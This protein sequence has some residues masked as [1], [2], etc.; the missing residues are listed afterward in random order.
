MITLL[1][2]LLAIAGGVW[3][4]L[5]QPSFGRLPQ[6]ERL[7]RI[8]KS[9]HYKDGEFK[10]LEVTPAITSKKSPWQT[11]ADFLFSDRSGLEPSEP[12]KAVKTDL[13][14]L[15]ED[16]NLIVWFGHSSYLLQ[17][18]GIKV[19][20]DPVF[21]SAAPVSFVMK[22]FKGTDIY[23]A[24]DMPDIDILVISHDHWDH[25]D[26]EVAKEMQPR[27]KYVVCGLGVGE[28]FER[29]GYEKSQ[30]IEM[31]WDESHSF[32]DGFAVDCLP[33]RHFSGR[34]LKRNPSLW[35]S[36]MLRTP[37]MNIF[38]GGDSGYGKHFKMIGERYEDID[39][40]IL[41]NGQYNED[42]RYIHTLPNQ[43]HQEVSDLGVNNVITVHHSKFALA[44]H[45][46]DEPLK[47]ELSLKE[48]TLL[49]VKILEIG[50]P[51]SLSLP[52]QNAVAE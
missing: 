36:Y 19:L 49:N 24:E 52:S 8:L 13:T 31:D 37:S 48:D 20:V 16:K 46:W 25:L 10:N 23:K 4:F 45:K 2:I 44:R 15:P 41:E 33:A 40:A 39:W 21:H 1:I 27:I 3:L 30:L 9:P 35:A 7:E 34:G 50:V 12:I 29:W 32:G 47:N 5:R 43:L 42:W 28:H 22:P 51:S 11:M 6:G 17:V 38:I 14:K 18:D 26:Y